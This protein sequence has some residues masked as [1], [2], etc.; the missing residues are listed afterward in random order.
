M[1]GEDFMN[2]AQYQRHGAGDK[3]TDDHTGDHQPDTAK[4]ERRHCN[5]N[6]LDDERH[7]QCTTEADTVRQQPGQQRPDGGANAEQHPILR[8]GLQPLPQAA[9]DEIHQENHVWHPTGRVECVFDI[10]RLEG[11]AGSSVTVMRGGGYRGIRCGPAPPG[12]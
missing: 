2:P 5:A 8:P 9:G 1:M 3:R 11:A 6:G 4:P 12:K 10:Q 7:P